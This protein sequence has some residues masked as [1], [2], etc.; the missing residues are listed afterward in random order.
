M[1]TQPDTRRRCRS[2]ARHCG[3]V[4]PRS[5]AGVRRLRRAVDPVVPRL[6]PGAGRPPRPTA[7]D[8]PARRSWR[9]GVL[10]RSLRRARAAKPSSPSRS[11]AAPTSSRRSRSPCSAGLERLLTWGV[12]ELAAD[13]R[14]RANPPIGRPAPRRRPRHPDGA[15]GRG[16]PARRRRRRRRCG[17]RALV[18]DSVGL[19]GADR[20]RNIAGRVR[21]IKPVAG[22]VLVVDDIVTTGATASES[23]RVL[24]TSQAPTWPVCLRSPMPDDGVAISIRD[25]TRV[26]N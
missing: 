7:P 11:T 9:A 2:A 10:A 3:H 26:K 23:V 20:Q 16:G 13:R 14:P 1:R 24:Q 18:R 25:Q 8:H 15:G 21:I 4:R 6:R 17:L 19:S 5:A 22:E 12:V